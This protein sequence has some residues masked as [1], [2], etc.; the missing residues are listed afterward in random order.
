MQIIRQRLDA[1]HIEQPAALTVRPTLPKGLRLKPPDLIPHLTL[2][3]DVI[4]D[5]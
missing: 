5:R 2:I 1:I 3:V 4:I